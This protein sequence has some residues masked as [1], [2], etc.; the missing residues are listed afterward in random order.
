MFPRVAT[1]KRGDKTY[2]Y[3]QIVEA[4]RCNGRTTQRVVAN[5][6]RLDQTR[7]LAGLDDLLLSLSQ[8]AQRTFVREDQIGCR[9][10]L[11]W[12]AVLLVRHL[13]DQMHMGDVLGKLCRPRR[14]TFDVAETAFVLVANRLCE[15]SSEH[16][17]A[18]WLEHTFVCDAQGQRWKPDWLP[19]KQITQQQ[20]VKVKHEQLNRWYRTLDALLAAKEQIEEALYLRVR[21]LFSIKVDLVFYDLTSTFFCRKSPVGRLRRHGHSKDGKPRQVQVML[22]VVMANGFPIAHHVFAG[23]TA[24]KTTLQHVLDDVDRRFGLGQVMVVADRGLVSAANLEFLSQSKFR[25]LLGL[26]G[27]RSQEAAAVFEALDHSRW[28]PV[29]QENQVQEIRLPDRPGRY[30][31][32]DSLPR[33]TYESALRERSMQ[34]SRAALEKVAVAVKAG[35]LKHP[36]KIGARAARAVARHHGHRYYSYEVRGSG[37]FRF[38]EDPAKMRAEI[39]H[40]GKYI[41]QTDDEEVGATEVVGAY[42]ELD[43]VESGFRDLKDVIEMRPVYHKKD[44]RIEAH[45]FVATLALFLKRSLEHQLASAL[46]ELSGQEAIAAMRSIGLAELSLNGQITR[47]VSG[48]GRDARRVLEALG[49][50]DLNPPRPPKSNSKPPGNPM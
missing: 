22:G 33:K 16:G 9:Q 25:Y 50:E 31:V 47:L 37:Q 11:P 28:Q 8:F 20:R 21:D 46:P 10:A 40:E 3:L 42:K 15:P 6:G 14:Y 49:I 43:T 2:Q 19:A 36:A 45:I 39:L 48:G 12:G 29:D 1:V 23:N 41:L 24:D 34:R 17:L 18:R 44:E 4:Y 5:L 35:R 38:W 30:L 27:R 7:R 32:I 13:W 26:P